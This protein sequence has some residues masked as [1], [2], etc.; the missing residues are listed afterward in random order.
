[1]VQTMA[2]VLHGVRSLHDASTGWDISGGPVQFKMAQHRFEPGVI[3]PRCNHN[4][5]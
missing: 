2:A 4:V 3:S 1:M 5:L